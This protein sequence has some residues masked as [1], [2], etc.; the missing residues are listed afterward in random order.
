MKTDNQLELLDVIL[1]NEE[2]RLDY[3]SF[4]PFL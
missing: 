1:T 3:D 4:L 2:N